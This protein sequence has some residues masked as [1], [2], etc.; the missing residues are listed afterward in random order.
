VPQYARLVRGSVLAVKALPYVEAARVIGASSPRIMLRHVLANAYAPVLVLSTLQIGNA[1]LIGSGLSFLGLGAQPPI[2]GMG[3]DVGRGARGAAQGV[4]DLDFP[5]PRDP[6]RRHRLQPARRRAALGSRPSHAGRVVT[7]SPTR[8]LRRRPDRADRFVDEGVDNV[9]DTLQRRVG[10][11]TLLIGTVSWLGLKVGRRI[12]HAL[13]GFPITASRRPTRCAAAP[14]S[15]PVRILRADAD[16][17]FRGDRSGAGRPRRA[18]HG[19]PRPRARG[20]CA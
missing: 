18:R 19:D 10:V 1:I 13:E 7:T 4:V 8:A 16:P 6:Q 11:D 3:P 2:P 20:G 5:R 15:A 14:T 12:S 9:L 17:R